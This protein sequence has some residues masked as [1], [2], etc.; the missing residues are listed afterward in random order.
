M[1]KIISSGINHKEY[2]ANYFKSVTN[3]HSI[4]SL[5]GGGGGGGACMKHAAA[6]YT[7]VLYRGAA[8][9]VLKWPGHDEIQ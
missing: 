4:I 7:H 2:I 6:Q 5:V 8:P 1:V 9:L 3:L